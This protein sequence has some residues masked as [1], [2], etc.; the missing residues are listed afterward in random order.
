MKKLSSKSTF[1]LKRVFPAIWF[2][3]IIFFVL[4]TLFA[5]QNN[6]MSDMIMI[7][8]SAIFMAA[9]GYFM[10]KYLVFDLMDEVYDEGLSLLFK[11]HGKTVR[12]NL[13]DIK[14]V[15]YTVVL[16]PPRVTINLRHKTE[17][18]DELSFSPPASLIPFRKNKEIVELIDRIDNAR[19]H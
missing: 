8:I 14:N 6:K 4:T 17:F 18:G 1:F 11:N 16:N 12:V 2:G 9:I 13:S 15:S 10:M 3:F 5:G 7:S 19:S